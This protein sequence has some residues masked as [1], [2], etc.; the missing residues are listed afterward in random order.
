MRLAERIRSTQV[1][2]GEVAL[3]YLAQAGFCIKTVDNKIMIIDAY[4]SD[5]C[6]RLFN[7]KRMTPSVITAEE[8]DADLYIS[9]H[10]HADHLD[11]DSLPVVVKNKK[12]FFLGSPDCEELYRQ[13]DISKER[14]IILKEGEEW[15]MAGIKIRAVHADHGELSPRANGL[16]INIDGIKIYHTGDTSF[17]PGEIQASLKTDVDIMI[18]PINGK[19]EN[20]NA[21]EACNLSLT[22]KPEILIASHF[23][24]FLEHV[25]EEGKGDPATF[26]KESADL[27]KEIKAIVMAPGELLKYSK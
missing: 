1:N 3:F 16:L 25:S 9:T 20:M 6:E 13:N 23:W 17:R 4:L 7:F 11:P 5:A 27:P 8:L 12:T 22:I 24:M 26:L 10:E 18:A 21:L 19:F 14:Y 2:K 15:E